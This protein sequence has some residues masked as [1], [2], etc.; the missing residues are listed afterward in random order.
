MKNDDIKNWTAGRKTD[1]VLRLLKGESIDSLSR[2]YGIE[3]YLIDQWKET[4]IHSATQGLKGGDR[5][6]V[7]AA[8]LEMAKKKIGQLS[9]DNELLLQRCRKQEAFRKG[10]LS[11]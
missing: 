4:F 7:P 8:D 5:K 10:R 2:E 1:V 3:S 11:P 6:V 9:M